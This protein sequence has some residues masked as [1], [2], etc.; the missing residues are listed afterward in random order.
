MRAHERRRG[1]L[2]AWLI[3]GLITACTSSPMGGTLSPPPLASQDQPTSV[4]GS[5]SQ[6]GSRE[7]VAQAD[8]FT[9][10]VT[11]DRLEVATGET[12]TFDATF[13]NGTDEPIDVAGPRCGA[14]ISAFVEVDLPAKPNGKAW[15]GI[16]KTFKDYV[17]TQAYGPGIV[18][19]FQ[20]L[21]L[22]LSGQE[23]GEH[24]I[25]S[26]LSPGASLSRSLSWTAEIVAGVEALP[27]PVPFTISAGYDQQNG[28]PSYPPDYDG[29]HGSWTPIFKALTVEGQLQV[30]GQGR[31]LLHAGEIIDAVL[32]DKKYAEWLAQRP[33][34]T[35]S[36]A[37]MFL[38]SSPT[39]EGILPK[40][41]AWDIDL[42]REVGVPRHWAIAF[43]DPFDARLISVH[44]CDIPCDR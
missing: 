35:W 6:A 1:G 32:A 25:S 12:M 41:P 2:M 17:L 29:P 38:V 10:T 20:P 31:V 34:K 16:R 19:A 27:G 13:H 14:G 28:P 18:P 43:I 11:A 24:T 33:A 15:T 22:D 3:A 21:R 26:E 40:G 44:Y 42:F 36:N 8:G 37:N 4:A 23:C 5:P 7:F 39:G 30:V 9:L